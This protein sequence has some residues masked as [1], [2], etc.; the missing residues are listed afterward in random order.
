M[1]IVLQHSTVALAACFRSSFCWKVNLCLRS[2][3]A[4]NRFLQK[5]EAT[6]LILLFLQDV[7]PF[8]QK[9]SS[10][11]MMGE[12]SSRNKRRGPVK[13]TPVRS[14]RRSEVMVT[15]DCDIL[16]D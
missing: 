2:S 10:V 3:Q 11:L 15:W 4:P 1:C 8:I 9:A 12:M 7:S 16:D 14:C 13:G 6:G 5:S